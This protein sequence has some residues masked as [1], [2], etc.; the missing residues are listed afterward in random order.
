MA[1]IGPQLRILRVK[2]KRTLPSRGKA[3]E[4]QLNEILLVATPSASECTKKRELTPQLPQRNETCYGALIDTSVRVVTVRF[5]IDISSLGRQWLQDPIDPT[6]HITEAALYYVDLINSRLPSPQQVE[7]REDYS[8]TV[9]LCVMLNNMQHTHDKL[10]STQVKRNGSE[11]GEQQ[12][13]FDELQLDKIFEWLQKE[14]GIGVQAQKVVTD[15]MTSAADDIRNRIYGITERLSQRFVPAIARIVVVK[16]MEADQ[17]ATTEE[18]LQPLDSYLNT[19]LQT[20]SSN[21]LFSVFKVLLK[22][23]W[24]ATIGVLGDTVSRVPKTTSSK[25]LIQRL[26]DSLK[27]LK[28][29]FHAGGEGLSDKDLEPKQYKIILGELEVKRLN[30]DELIVK[31]CADMVEQQ[32]KV[33]GQPEHKHGT[34]SLSVC[35]LTQKG[36]VEV[37]VGRAFNLPGTGKKGT[38]DPLVEASLLPVLY[39]PESNRKSYK[40]HAQKQTVN[41][42]FGQEFLLPAKGENMG[43]EGAILVLTI[44]DHD[45]IRENTFVGICVVPCKDIPQLLDEAP[46]VLDRTAPQRKNLTLPLFQLADSRCF[47]ELNLRNQVDYDHESTDFVKLLNKK[48]QTPT[49]P[50]VLSRLYTATKDAMYI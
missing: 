35:Y 47:R 20:L 28:V 25:Y 24:V 37:T 4:E 34:L 36:V 40:T 9:Q 12:N 44:F 39:F 2:K 19:N 43:K 46:S 23:I 38:L 49:G 21:L 1:T 6:E 14:K 27:L 42:T 5:N 30:S 10:L 22:H 26:C 13:L 45:L 8:V 41:P 33:A 31:C 11:Q 18:L 15:I 7:E 3:S 17:K 50:G 16:M 32:A 29:F 48:Y